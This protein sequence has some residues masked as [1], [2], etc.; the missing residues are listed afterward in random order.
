[1]RPTKRSLTGAAWSRRTERGSMHG[2]CATPRLARANRSQREIEAD[3]C[4]FFPGGR[5]GGHPSHLA[6]SRAY[7]CPRPGQDRL[8]GKIMPALA[9]RV[10][11]RQR[12]NVP[13]QLGE[14]TSNLAIP[15]P[16]HGLSEDLRLKWGRLWQSPVAALFDPVSDL[17]AL[18]RLFELYALG[19]RLDALI[20]DAQPRGAAAAALEDV[21]EL[22]PLSVAMAEAEAAG[23]RQAFNATIGA[24]L[25]VA[26]EVRMLEGQLGLSPRSRLALGLTVLAGKAAATAATGGLDAFLEES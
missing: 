4:A 16:P 1:M 23:A 9:K 19:G 7:A 2:R 13:A 21:D 17:P 5:A 20:A 14:F 18:S 11:D 15:L 25:R 6:K 26:T 3:R 12:R 10:E 24:R 22:D 8:G